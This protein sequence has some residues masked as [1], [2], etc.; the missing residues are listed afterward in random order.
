MTLDNFLTRNS[1]Q[2]R[3]TGDNIC[4][5]CPFCVERGESMDTRFRLGINVKTGLSHCFNCRWKGGKKSV[6]F[7][8]RRLGIESRFE[9][10]SYDQDN[11]EESAPKP[12]MAEIS[13][14]KDF[15]PLT[16]CYD[17]VDEAARKY[18]LSRGVTAEQIESK[19]IGVSYVGRYAYRVIFPVMDGKHLRG[20]AAR[21][22]TGMETKCKYLNST[23]D[24]Y[25]YN[26]Q[27]AN[28]IILCE[29][30]FKALRLETAAQG[31]FAAMGLLGHDLTDKQLAQVVRSGC[32]EVLLWPDP[33]RAGIRG[34]IT[35]ADKLSGIV[36]YISVMTGITKPADEEPISSLRD[37]LRNRRGASYSMY[38]Q[39]SM[40]CSL[41]HR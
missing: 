23:G 11:E 10:F 1:I 3:R 30:V 34:M 20:F 15:S 9:S 6:S 14:P 41:M 22:F 8:M 18:V 25:L 5:C 24:K 27:K 21:D 17:D 38:L 7:I 12:A 37:K 4:V 16:E 29:G 32:K 36:R 31:E 39:R 33:D 26:F 28:G 19:G 2:Y 35:V 40:K 13:L